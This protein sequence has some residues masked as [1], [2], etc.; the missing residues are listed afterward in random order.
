M[1]LRPKT[2]LLPALA[3]VCIA[4]AGLGVRAADDKKDAQDPKAA[5]P[6]KAALTVTVT[7][8]QRTQLPLRISANGN[9]AAWQEASVGTEA[10]G[11]RLAEVRANVGDVVKKGQVLAVFASDT[12]EADLMQAKAAVS[13]AEAMLAEATA[14]ARRAREL[15]PAGA[16]SGQQIEN[17]LTGERT[18][19][20][21]LEAARA[22]YKTAQLRVAQARVVA[23]DSGVISA[24]SATVG[25]VLPAGQE[26]FRLIR[27]GRL[28]WR[29]EVPANDLARVKP[30]MPASVMATSSGAPVL[31]KVRIVAPTVDAQTRNG[32][33]YVDLTASPEVKAGMYARGE[34]DI[35][36]SEALTLPQGAVVLRDG[37]HYVLKVGPDQKV[38]QAKVGVGRRVGE[39]IEITSG[40]DAQTRVVAAGG[41]FLADGDVVRVVEAPRAASAPGAA[42]KPVA[43]R[44]P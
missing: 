42:V 33:V 2:V 7:Q 23:P 16:L 3:L 14:N 39:R 17:Y 19:Q 37:F 40:L 35:G 9:I 29:A 27:Q 32:L 8:A 13:E 28:E 26:L 38:T 24:R 10:N 15:G 44:K 25:A 31:G 41:G 1:T 6:A 11:L 34:F 18:A 20:A 43:A 21:R 36:Q 5:A 4:L 30:G 12:V 22:S